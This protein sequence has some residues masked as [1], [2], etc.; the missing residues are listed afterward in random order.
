MK[1]LFDIDESSDL[2]KYYC[3]NKP[4][5]SILFSIYVNSFASHFHQFNDSNEALC[6]CQ[7]NQ[8]KS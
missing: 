4:S 6:K 7:K 3:K 1:N 5:I 2:D 8:Q